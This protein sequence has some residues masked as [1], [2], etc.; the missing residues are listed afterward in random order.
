MFR[1]GWEE[2]G[3]DVD[4]IVEQILAMNET[5]IDPVEV[6]PSITFGDDEYVFDKESGIYD[7]N[8]GSFIEP[9]NDPVE[10]KD[11]EAKVSDDVSKSCDSL[12]QETD[13][14]IQ[15]VEAIKPNMDPVELGDGDD[16][17]IDPDVIDADGTAQT[18]GVTAEDAAGLEEGIDAEEAIAALL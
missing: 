11:L 5:E 16:V 12:I 2:S 3:V 9:L 18:A 7:V 1:A 6:A 4:G 14:D 10:V 15:D 13:I 17:D 8:G